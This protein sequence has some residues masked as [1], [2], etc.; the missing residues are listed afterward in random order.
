MNDKDARITFRLSC[1]AKQNLDLLCRFTGQKPAEVVRAGIAQ[2]MAPYFGVIMSAKGIPNVGH[3]SDISHAR[4]CVDGNSKEL[5]NNNELSDNESNNSNVQNFIGKFLGALE[6]K[7]FPPRVAR[8]IKE[9]WEHIEM[10]GVDATELADM[11]NR[12]CVIE[13]QDGKKFCDPNSWIK[14]HGFLNETIEGTGGPQYDTDR[15]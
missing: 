10:F 14:N 12:Y 13:H 8:A 1:E 5:P 3:M 4:T 2:M 9:E 6:N 11:Y 15:E 7:K